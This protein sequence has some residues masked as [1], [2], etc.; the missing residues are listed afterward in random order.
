M[1]GDP[2]GTAFLPSCI[3]AGLGGALLL[4]LGCG[5]EPERSPQ[6]GEPAEAAYEQATEHARSGQ[7][8]QAASVVLEVLPNHPEDPDLHFRLGYVLRYGGLLE[9]SMVAYA[10][11]ISLDDTPERRVSGEGQ[12]AKSLIY[13]GRYDEALDLQQGL[14]DHLRELGQEPD[15][16]MLFYEGV[17]HLYRGD[18]AQAVELFGQAEERDPE[19]LWTEFGRAYRDALQADTTSL[20]ARLRDLRHRDVADGERHYRLVH[21]HAL[22]GEPEEAVARLPTAMEGGFFAYPYVATDPLLGDAVRGHPQFAELL[23]TIRERHEAFAA[24]VEEF[25]G[26]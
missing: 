6:V 11:G 21:L 19:S 7:P 22:A 23:D 4:L 9:E 13:A 18:T 8:E 15:E 24:K 17:I 5:S 12:I 3:R 26:T 16:K 10:R 2:S 1:I 20:R 14:R 25:D